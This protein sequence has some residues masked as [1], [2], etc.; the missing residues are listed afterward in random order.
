MGAEPEAPSMDEVL[1]ELKRKR[2][3]ALRSARSIWLTPA[4]ADA[5]IAYFDN[6]DA[7]KADIFTRRKGN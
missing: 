6:I 2:G 3:V 5:I 7:F 1:A 4:E